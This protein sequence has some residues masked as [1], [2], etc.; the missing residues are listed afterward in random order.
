MTTLKD[1][2]TDLAYEVA[3][4][5]LKMDA[6]VPDKLRETKLDELVEEYLHIIKER[7]IGD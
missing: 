3:Q 1:Y 4:E 5:I 6:T 2:L 7:L